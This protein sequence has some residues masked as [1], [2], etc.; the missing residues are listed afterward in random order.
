[1]AFPRRVGVRVAGVR[2]AGAVRHEH[3]EKEDGGG[4]DEEERPKPRKSPMGAVGRAHDTTNHVG[5]VNSRVKQHEN[6][7]QRVA[8]GVK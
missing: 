8:G 5:H 7:P 3:V 2:V 6:L 1:M 4:E